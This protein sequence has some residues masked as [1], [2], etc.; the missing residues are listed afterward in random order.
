MNRTDIDNLYHLL[1][2]LNV[3]GD[4]RE[5]AA[6]FGIT[7][8]LTGKHGDYSGLLRFLAYYGEEY[9]VEHAHTAIKSA[10]FDVKRIVELGAGY[11][12]LS[13]GLNLLMFGAAFKNVLTIDKRQWP[14]IDIVADI[15][16][17]NGLHRVL[18]ELHPGD[19]IV[20]SEFLHCLDNPK[21]TLLPF[22]RFPMIIVEYSTTGLYMES[23]NAQIAKFGCT[24]I[25]SIE[26]VF[27]NQR[28]EQWVVSPYTITAVQPI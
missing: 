21:E 4:Q 9:L 15:E 2:E 11:G 6:I 25:P 12:W 27:P 13:R 22:R 28:C 23:Y 19:L 16:S 17:K 24:S 18:D 10:R 5:K 14:M 20:M 7:S 26:N 8:H 3:E 1:R